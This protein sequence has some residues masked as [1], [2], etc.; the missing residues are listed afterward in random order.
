MLPQTWARGRPV[1]FPHTFACVR[2]LGCGDDRLC[3]LAAVGSSA[4]RCV[5]GLRQGAA[6]L[7]GAVGT[8][9][10]LVPSISKV[11]CVFSCIMSPSSSKILHDL[12]RRALIYAVL[13]LI[14]FP[15]L[16][17]Q[18]HFVV[19]TVSR[20]R[21]FSFYAAFLQRLWRDLTNL[22]TFKP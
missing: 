2:C 3:C 6:L 4:G 10:V 16:K 1:L 15:S 22:C 13:K 7:M 9:T 8:N 18:K 14:I 11:T 5:W 12:V 19:C 21:C 17:Y 20:F